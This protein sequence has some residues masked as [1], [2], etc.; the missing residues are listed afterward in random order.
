MMGEKEMPPIAGEKFYC[1]IYMPT[2]RYYLTGWRDILHRY[3]RIKLKYFKQEKE[4][5]IYSLNG[6]FICSFEAYQIIKND[7]KMM[8][9][10]HNLNRSV[11]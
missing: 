6:A 11:E 4:L 1:S 3:F 8:A 2:Y 7:E 9:G 5:I 10:L